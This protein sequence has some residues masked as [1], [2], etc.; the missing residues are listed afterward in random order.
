[1]LDL[2][3]SDKVVSGQTSGTVQ[4][5]VTTAVN[6][7]NLSATY[8]NIMYVLPASVSFGG[9]AAYAYIGSSLSVY[10]KQYAT[11]LQVLVHELGHNL[12]HL[13][14]GIGSSSYG[15][16][17]GMMGARVWSDNSPRMCFNGA[18]SW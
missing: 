11:H 10:W 4:G 8:S 7:L 17:A 18:K 3:L 1:M 13:H 6:Q 16:G 9:A 15:D 14:S 2:T 12:R 5:W